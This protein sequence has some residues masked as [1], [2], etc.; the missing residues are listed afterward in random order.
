VA[1]LVVVVLI[2]VEGCSAVIT[3]TVTVVVVLAAMTMAM[4]VTR[5]VEIMVVEAAA[6]GAIMAEMVVAVAMAA[7]AVV[8]IAVTMTEGLIFPLG[9]IHEFCRCSN[10]NKDS[11]SRVHFNDHRHHLLPIL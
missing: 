4:V 8:G 5:A 10:N 11:T 2:A 7:V 1:T 9:T 6:T 3:G